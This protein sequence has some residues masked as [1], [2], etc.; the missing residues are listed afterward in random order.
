MADP[1]RDDVGR[2]LL[3]NQGK[4]G[5]PEWD[6][7]VRAW[8]Q[9]GTAQPAAPEPKPFDFNRDPALV[10]ADIA[11]IPDEQM[12][13][14]MLDAFGDAYVAN[15]RAQ[16]MGIGGK[17][18][19]AVTGVTPQ[20]FEDVGRSLVRGMPFGTWADELNAKTA[21]LTGQSSE[22]EALAYQRAK[23]RAF[24]KAHPVINAA[25]QLAGGVASA[26]A[27]MIRGGS[28][29]ANLLG[30]AGINTVLGGIS[31]AGAAERP[32]DRASGA[33]WGA[34]TAAA[35]SALLSPLQ[36]AGMR[37]SRVSPE[38]QAAA[39]RLAVDT[40]FFV[41]AQDP[42]VRAAGRQGAQMTPGSPLAQAWENAYRGTQ[43]AGGSIVQRAT[44][45]GTAEAPR[46]AGNAVREGVTGARDV[47]R[48]DM[49]SLANVT[50][51]VMPPG[52]RGNPS[53]LRNALDTIVA[54]R[55]EA[56]LPPTPG[57]L[58]N[59]QSHVDLPGGVPWRGSNVFN[60]ELGRQAGLPEGRK[61]S[62]EVFSDLY[63]SYQGADRPRFVEEAAG[64][65]AR[66]VFET[67]TAGQRGLGDLRRTLNE[68]LRTRDPAA[69][70]SML[71]DAATVRGGGPR[72]NTLEAVLAQLN[73]QQREQLAGG[74]LATY[75]NRAQS[76]GN[77][78]A[79]RLAS[80]LNDMAPS[81]RVG[82]YGGT[83]GIFPNLTPTGHDV[84]ALATLAQ[85]IGQVAGEGH[86]GSAKTLGTGM[87]PQG[88][89]GTAATGAVLAPMLAAGLEPTTG[90]AVA[91]AARGAGR[92]VGGAVR[93]HLYQH[94]VPPWLSD[95]INAVSA[96]VARAPMR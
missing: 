1:T 29:G 68:A 65:I 92:G 51:A 80:Q 7:M 20:T 69:M 86:V 75:M 21:A 66:S 40:P 74:I 32:E 82:T 30:N 9:L 78:S 36:A 53:E 61:V 41:R 12:R 47:A 24:T 57:F 71:A 42:M 16:P 10:R 93:P 39:D 79:A 22:E 85:R 73:P 13:T 27:T 94:G 28:I 3:S 37:Y 91:L 19:H 90:A 48:A 76:G 15:E 88:G 59:V 33:L 2:W 17:L 35:L 54:G 70:T 72:L 44:G 60:T 95:A 56:G 89:L 8:D 77:V 52:Y 43:E 81:A 55:T 4:K 14:K 6:T 63:R 49:R 34:G 87:V 96:G 31:G 84:D 11:K 83:P 46:I 67:T 50:N 25:T 62:Q 64:P 5:T 58:A 26:P 23:D 45:A 38:V 18:L